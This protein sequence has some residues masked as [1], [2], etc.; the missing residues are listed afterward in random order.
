MSTEYRSNGKKKGRGNRKNGNAY[1]ARAF[2]EAAHFAIR[3]QPAAKSF[4]QRK[5]TKT[6][7]RIAASAV[8]HKL[9]RAAYFMLRDGLP[10]R[11]ELL[12]GD[13]G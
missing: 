1:L 3:Y 5:K 9:A 12:F 7:G 4:Y 2:G 13:A 6:N 8:A 11:P 10:Y